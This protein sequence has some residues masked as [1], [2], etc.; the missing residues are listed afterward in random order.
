VRTLIGKNT[1]QQLPSTSQNFPT[2]APNLSNIAAGTSVTGFVLAA[3]ST[4]TTMRPSAS[5]A[6]GFEKPPPVSY[7]EAAAT[8]RLAPAVSG[9][10]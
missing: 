6:A 1:T 8:D 2:R 5:T 9:L 4:G 3:L 10:D 7:A